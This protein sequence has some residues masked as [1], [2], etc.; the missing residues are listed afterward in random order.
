MGEDKILR[1]I[2]VGNAPSVKGGITSVISQ[3]LSHNWNEQNIEMRFIPT[4]E[5]G[6][7]VNKIKAFVRGY[8]QLQRECKNGAVDVVHIHMSHN[9]SLGVFVLF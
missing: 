4:F 7:A 2:T 8:V 6:G 3:I 5:G 9:G 1:V